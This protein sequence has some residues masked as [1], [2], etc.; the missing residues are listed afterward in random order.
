MKVPLKAVL[1]TM[2]M[3]LCGVPF[4]RA[5]SNNIV[6]GVVTSAQNEPLIGVTVMVENTTNGTVTD[7]D[8]NFSIAASPSDKLVFSYIGYVSQTIEVGDQTHIR[9]QMAEENEMLDELVVIGYGSVK[10]SDL[11]GAI[12]SVK[13]DQLENTA[14]AG[15]ESALQGKVP[16][17]LITKNSGQP[18]GETDIKI[19]GVGSFNS[20]GP[21]WVIDGVPQTPGTKFNMNDAESVEILRDGSA[22]AIYGASAANGVI[23]VTTKR[24]KEGK[25]RVNFNAYV[26]FNSPANMPDMLTTQQLKSLRLEDYRGNVTTYGVDEKTGIDMSKYNGYGPLSGDQM[27][28][29]NFP[30]DYS[31][32][33]G[34]DIRAYAPDFEYTNADYHWGDILFSTGITQNYDLSFTQGTDKY[35]Y[36]ASFNYYNEEGTFVDTGFKRY[37]FRLNSDVK[38]TKWL[39]FGESLQLVYTDQN[40]MYNASTFL[41]AY[42]RVMPFCIPYDE[43]NQPGGYGFFQTD[44]NGQPLQFEDL[45]DPSKTTTIKNMLD[46]YDGGNPLAEEYTNHIQNTNFDVT[47]N[48]YLNIQPIKQLSIRAVFAGGMGMSSNR[49]ERETYKYYEA[50]EY[51]TPYVKQTLSRSHELRGQLYA[52]YHDT[53]AEDHD[54]AVMIGMEGVKSYGVTLNGEASNMMG[55]AYQI[56]L[57]E[58]ADRLVSDSYSNTAALSYFGRVNYT[59]K[60]RYMFMALVRRDGYDRFGPLNRWGT[61]PSFSGAWRIS[62]ENFLKEN[63]NAWWLSNL[64]LRASWGRLGNVGIQQFL[65]TTTYVTTSS[66]YTW[67]STND[68]GDQTTAQGVHFSSLPNQSIKWED[69]TTTNVGVDMGVLN[70]TLMFSVDGYVKN[71]TDA[72]FKSSLPGMAGIGATGRD[73]VT[74]VTNVGAIRNVG[75]DFEAT[76]Q[77]RIGKDFNFAVNVNLGYVKNKVLATNDAEEVLIAGPTDVKVAYTQVGYEMGMFRAYD[78]EGVF[79]TP[80]EVAEYNAMA[81]EKSNG[82]VQYYQQSGTGAGDL[83]Y[84]DVNGDG[85]IDSDDITIVGSPWPDLTYGFNLSFNWRWLDFLASFQGVYGNEIYNN[86]RKMTHTFNL[87]YNTTTYALNRWTGPGSTNEDFRMSATDPNNNETTLSSWFVEDGSYLRLKNLQVGFSLPAKWMEKA[88]MSKCRLYVSGQNLLTFTKY[89]GFD[90]EFNTKDNTA[91]GIDTGYYPQNRTILCGVQI[92]F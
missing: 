89:E 8:G 1:L 64:K 88:H 70:N 26:G 78:V 62:E 12:S 57:A 84:R 91:A 61:F 18:G 73:D 59:Y 13:S 7:F 85:H 17:V 43:K 48:V 22:A 20:S 10:K 46:R 38:L 58:Q 25:T 50:K 30:T 4:V 14:S 86:Y 87:D 56:R 55:G 3:L 83:K 27:L 42:M 21:L 5:Q 15:I 68:A 19:R 33:N 32:V 74:Y 71:T 82:E 11:T 54:L 37:S 92:E 60:D 45:T 34:V 9:V 75:V 65:Y 77:N 63:D 81:A 16:G 39:T 51:L 2:T 47:G 79:Q 41:N 53:F 66:N 31:R 40:P 72:I 44:E 36:Y 49:I 28:M 29:A 52:N 6:T 24:G 76:Y 23:L 90:P 35:N 80:E 67:G 69:I